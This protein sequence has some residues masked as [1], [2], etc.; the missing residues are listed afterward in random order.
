MDALHVRYGTACIFQSRSNL[1]PINQGVL[2]T[3]KIEVKIQGIHYDL[4]R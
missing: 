2:F 3:H 1:R 4:V